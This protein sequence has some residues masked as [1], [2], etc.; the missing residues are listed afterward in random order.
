MY[1]SG[2]SSSDVPLKRIL[3]SLK[4]NYVFYTAVNMHTMECSPEVS[5][6]M[7]KRR[8][9]SLPHYLRHSLV[10]AGLAVVGVGVGIANFVVGVDNGP[11][12]LTGGSFFPGI[13]IGICAILGY[14]L[15]Q[16][17]NAH[18][19]SG[20]IVFKAKCLFIAHYVMSL[21]TAILSVA[22]IA[23]PIVGIVWCSGEVSH[24]YVRINRVNYKKNV[25][26]PDNKTAALVTGGLAAV[27]SFLI[28]A[29][30]ILGTVFFCC[31]VRSYGFQSRRIRYL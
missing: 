16:T 11:F 13:L 18:Q 1:H 6:A 4:E 8:I 12:H 31:F 24:Y 7:R 26:C 29:W 9:N 27:D 17:G 2:F 23:L 25:T 22:F 3:I 15:Y 14:Q 10:G 5:E 28:C 30:C 21:L 19:G 20:E